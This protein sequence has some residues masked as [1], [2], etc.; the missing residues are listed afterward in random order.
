MRIQLSISAAILLVAA[1]LAA[2]A[3]QPTPGTTVPA[4]QVA[5]AHGIPLDRVVAVVGDVVITQSDLQERLIRKRQEGTTP[6]TDSAGF[7]SFLVTTVGEL[8][9][10]QLLLQKS[11]EL[12][13]EV[14]D[15]DVSNTVDRQVKDIRSRFPT[16]TEYRN[17]LQK[18]GYGTPD[19]YKRMLLDN[20]KREETITRTVRKLK[21]DG[22]LVQ[23][24]V[25][26]A[27]VEDSYQRN[28]ATLPRREPSV[29]W[30][31][32]VIAPHPTPAAR[33]LARVKAESLLAEIRSGG[34]FELLA[35]RESMDPGSREKG[36]D[37]GWNRRGVMVPEFDRWMFGLAPGQLSPVV[38]SVFGYHIIRVDRVQPSEVKARHI[39]IAPKIDSADVV[40][41]HLEADSVAAAWRA[42]A[43]FDSLAK[44]HH[45]FASKEETT[46]LTPFPR[47]QLPSA[48]Q[49]AFGD[50][51]AGD[52][53]VFEIGGT[54]TVPA[55][56]V[57]VQLATV[58]QGGELTLAEVKERFRA[59]L[60][61][62]GGVKR[63]MESLRK[64]TYVS[65]RTDALVVTPQAPV[66]GAAPAP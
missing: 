7:V 5:N 21:D 47:A 16:E 54:G 26:D 44:H 51:K 2:Q 25:T 13:I 65:V 23:A 52:L 17:E 11:K 18:A 4:V 66:P 59:R 34:D 31:Q 61:E 58:E 63:L 55:K 50:H 56:F 10:E 29:S 12:K 60:A 28:K 45:D 38:Q 20:V 37:L 64:G 6:P 8:V 41:A 53:F 32:I 30:R 1:P 22:K 46:L 14:A 43:P 9:D 49:T 3:Q 15:A 19:E 36:G 24:N 62:E 40:R 57:V 48:Y 27:E 33:E 42:G 35:K 39:L